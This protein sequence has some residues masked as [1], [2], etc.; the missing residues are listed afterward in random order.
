MEET[1][2]YNEGG[3]PWLRLRGMETGGSCSVSPPDSARKRKSVYYRYA[4]SI[5]TQAITRL[6]NPHELSRALGILTD[7]LRNSWQNSE[8]MEQLRGF[9][10]AFPCLRA[11][12]E[13]IAGGYDILG[14]LLRSK[15]NLINMTGFETLF[16]FLGL[17]F[18]STE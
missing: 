17:N 14:H 18:R 3:K 11:R 4:V 8:D 1:R 12:P 16:E 13:C 6:Q 9:P 2:G 5:T 10:S 15:A 7:G